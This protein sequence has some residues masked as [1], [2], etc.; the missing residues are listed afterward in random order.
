LLGWLLGLGISREKILNY[1][2]AVQA[3]KFL[4]VVRGSG[5]AVERAREILAGFAAERLD[6]HAPETAQPAVAARFR[7][8]SEGEPHA[9]CPRRGGT[10]ALADAAGESGPLPA[11]NGHRP[12]RRPARL[13]GGRAAGRAGR[14]SAL[15][16]SQVK[17]GADC[18]DIRRSAMSSEQP[19][20]VGPSAPRSS[21]AP[22]GREEIS[23]GSRRLARAPSPPGCR[24]ATVALAVRLDDPAAL[25]WMRP[26]AAALAHL[27]G[28][29]PEWR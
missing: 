19:A 4:L 25:G 28:V 9:P 21:R 26:V 13:D 2:E 14:R 1:E 29:S 7:R 15:T 23:D 6:Q 20:S 27:A 12:R 24:P 16:G 5:E 3:G 10:T 8:H 17:C 22:S 18:A 11:A